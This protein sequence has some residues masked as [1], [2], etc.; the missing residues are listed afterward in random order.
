MWTSLLTIFS[1]GL[2][3]LDKLMPSWEW[4]GGRAEVRAEVA[5]KELDDV[6]IAVEIDENTNRMS[7]WERRR[8]LRNKT[9]R[10]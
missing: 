9:E 8:W 10:K 6:R 4:K 5:E 3:V 7:D 1:K 2:S